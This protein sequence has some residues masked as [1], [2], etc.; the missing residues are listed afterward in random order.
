MSTPVLLYDGL[1]GFCNATVQFILRNE[2]RH[3]LRFA[4]LQGGFAAGV[5]TRHPDLAQVD[6]L[7]W[8]EGEGALEVARVR[9]DAALTVAA[10]LGGWWRFWQ[11]FR[12][13]PRVVRD[14]MYDLLARNRFRF[15]GRHDT[16]PVPA[17]E[18]RARF[19]D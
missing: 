4:A 10:Y 12:L 19:V 7:V 8:V 9:S 6:S 15:F 16:C 5:I 13:I 3:F 18:V 1:C 17:S 14:A 11:I 2:R